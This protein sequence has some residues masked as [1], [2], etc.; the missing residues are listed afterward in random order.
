[1]AGVADAIHYAHGQGVLHRDLKPR[2]LLTGEGDR[3]YVSDFE[4]GREL[5][6]GAGISSTGTII[7]TPAYMPPEA[8]LG[9]PGCWSPRADIYSLGATLYAL[10]A[11]REPFEG[12][13]LLEILSRVAAGRF[14]PL[15]TVAPS[16][17]PDLEAVVAK[18]M[19]REPER[20]H[21]TAAEL[22]DE[23]GRFLRGEPILPPR[24]PSALNLSPEGFFGWPGQG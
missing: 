11:G 14:A 8:A 2:N 10:L 1:M 24:P 3:V 4:L 21:V 15:R 16:A 22:A 13:V 7:G 12:D 18:A 5:T 6:A 23:L 20:R 19:S 17:P 9:K